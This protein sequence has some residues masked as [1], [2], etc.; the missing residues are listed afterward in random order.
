MVEIGVA[1]HPESGYMSRNRP[2]DHEARVLDWSPGSGCAE[3]AVNSGG[4]VS[5]F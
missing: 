2:R 5:A 1:L 4:R 3:G